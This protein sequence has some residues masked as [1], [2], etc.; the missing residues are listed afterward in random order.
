MTNQIKARD[1]F[2]FYRSFYS[3]TK[4]LNQIEKA[5]LFDVICSYALDGKI[6][7][8]SG[9]AEGMFELIK[10]QLNANRKRFKNG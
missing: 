4:C 8:L 9:T 2:I 3:A 6:E 10:P 1:S 5:Q 7:K